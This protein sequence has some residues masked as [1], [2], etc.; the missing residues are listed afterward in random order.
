MSIQCQREGDG[1]DRVPNGCAPPQQ[2]RTF[3]PRPEG[4]GKGGGRD[5]GCENWRPTHPH[6]RTV[7]HCSRPSCRLHARR[8]PGHSIAGAHLLR[9]PPEESPPDGTVSCAYPTLRGRCPAGSGPCRSVPSWHPRWLRVGPGAAAALRI[10]VHGRRAQ[11]RGEPAPRGRPEARRTAAAGSPSACPDPP[12]VGAEPRGWPGLPDRTPLPGA[13][14]RPRLPWGWARRPLVADAR[15]SRDSRPAAARPRAGLLLAPG[16][17]SRRPAS[18]TAG[19]RGRKA[20]PEMRGLLK[21]QRS[22]SGLWLPAPAS[23]QALA[24]PANHAE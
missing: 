11:R 19:A 16:A 21:G 9:A 12:A 4:E 6:C 1:P 13:L 22:F 2:A 5:P 8:L 18:I 23:A 24:P 14:A 20:G 7:C 10:R 3:L 17:S 15:P